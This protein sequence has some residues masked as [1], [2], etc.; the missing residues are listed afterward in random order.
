[1]QGES[2]KVG[3]VIN[4]TNLPCILPPGRMGLGQRLNIPVLVS[5][6]EGAGG[7]LTVKE[8]A[9][10]ASAC[11]L[12]QMQ[13]CPAFSCPR[14]LCLNTKRDSFVLFWH[15]LKNPS[16]LFLAYI[17]FDGSLEAEGSLWHCILYDLPLC[18]SA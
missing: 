5:Y 12:E 14:S 3:A 1:M 10:L 2:S 8:S 4:S 9:P 18:L 15:V 7:E 6:R 11:L 17:P 13:L 16:V